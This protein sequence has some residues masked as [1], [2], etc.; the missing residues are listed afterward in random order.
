MRSLTVWLCMLR[1]PSVYSLLWFSGWLRFPG[2]SQF[3]LRDL[4][5]T[6]SVCGLGDAAGDFCGGWKKKI[7][8]L[9]MGTGKSCSHTNHSFCVI[10]PVGDVCWGTGSEECT[11]VKRLFPWKWA[12]WSEVCLYRLAPGTSGSTCLELNTLSWNTHFIQADKNLKKNP[13]T[14]RQTKHERMSLCKTHLLEV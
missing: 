10:V 11:P 14:W 7:T 12:H 8:F 4:K 13:K 9:T 5:L 1:T 6:G 3:V 2:D